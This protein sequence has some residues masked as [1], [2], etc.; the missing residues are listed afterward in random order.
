MA[1]LRGREQCVAL[2]LSKNKIFFFY[3][4]AKWHYFAP[5]ILFNDMN[6]LQIFR[7]IEYLKCLFVP[8]YEYIYV[9]IIF[10]SE[11][12]VTFTSPS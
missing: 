2:A 11:P 9:I 7:N 8:T 10:S 5:S 3:T 12:L 1:S 6:K 4:V